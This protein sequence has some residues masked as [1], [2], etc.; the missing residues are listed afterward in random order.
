MMFEVI[1][2]WLTASLVKYG[3]SSLPEILITAAIE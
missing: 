3:F 2:I 1:V